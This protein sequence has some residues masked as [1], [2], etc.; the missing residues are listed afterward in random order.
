[1]LNPATEA[2]FPGRRHIVA[3]LEDSVQTNIDKKAFL[4]EASSKSEFDEIYFAAPSL[5]SI[6]TT[7]IPLPRGALNLTNRKGPSNNIKKSCIKSTMK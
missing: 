4:V 2:S 3:P 5:V 6:P 1:L 7:P